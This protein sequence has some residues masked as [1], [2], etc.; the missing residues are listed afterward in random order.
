MHIALMGTAQY[1]DHEAAEDPAECFCSS[2]FLVGFEVELGR[3]EWPVI[4]PPPCAG[5]ENPELCVREPGIS[6]CPCC[7]YGRTRCP[8][9]FKRF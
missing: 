8:K 4:T 7:P 5:L 6:G 3:D 1:C 9:F 2:P